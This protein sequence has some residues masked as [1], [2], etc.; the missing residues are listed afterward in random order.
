VL[1]FSD[2]SLRVREYQV[3]KYAVGFRVKRERL[4]RMWPIASWKGLSERERVAGVI[5]KWM[6]RCLA[7]TEPQ[8]VLAPNLPSMRA[9]R[10]WDAHG[11]PLLIAWTLAC[12]D[13][14]PHD[15]EAVASV[16]RSGAHTRVY[17]PVLPDPVYLS[18]AY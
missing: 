13:V 14:C 3:Q 6:L 12:R 7:R 17:V 10:W 16:L 18:R 15:R 5:R 1:V 2:G 4:D 11:G 9:D 8:A